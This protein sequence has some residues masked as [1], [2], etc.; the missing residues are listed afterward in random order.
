VSVAEKKNFKK[1]K[2][3]IPHNIQEDIIRNEEIPEQFNES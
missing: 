2:I 1:L 3:I